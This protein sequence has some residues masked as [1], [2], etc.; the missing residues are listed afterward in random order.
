MM[1]KA[2]KNRMRRLSQLCLKFMT[3]R[4][5]SL[6]KK[7]VRKD[8]F[9]KRTQIN[10]RLRTKT[11]LVKIREKELK[12]HKSIGILATVKGCCDDF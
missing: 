11:Q 8:R 6:Q 1:K 7:K 12:N 2:K 10:N 4:I 9:Y 3:K 5:T